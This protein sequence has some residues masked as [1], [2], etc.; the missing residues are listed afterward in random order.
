MQIRPFTKAVIEQSKNEY[1]FYVGPGVE[2][3]RVLVS[4]EPQRLKRTAISAEPL[5]QFSG[6][7]DSLV[8]IPKN[9]T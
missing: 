5:S 4:N 2:N 9:P 7:H 3:T 6:S 1:D 8:K